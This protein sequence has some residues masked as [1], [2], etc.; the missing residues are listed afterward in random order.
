[1]TILQIS[2]YAP[3]DNDPTNLMQTADDMRVGLH[4]LTITEYT[5]STV[6]AIAAGSVI[7]VNGTLFKA[8]SETAISGSPSNGT[9]YVYMVPSGSSPS[10]VLTPTFTNTAPTWFD[11]KQGWYDATGTYRYIHFAMTK[12]G[13]SY[14]PKGEMLFKNN[15]T[16]IVYSDGNIVTT[17]TI[18]GDLIGGVTETGAAGSVIKIKIINIGDWNMD[19]SAS[20]SLT[21]GL[22]HDDIRGV[23]A[24]IRDD[25]GTALYPLDFD[26]GSGA[27][28]RILL[29]S[30]QIQA[31]RTSGALFDGAS[32]DATSFNRGWV[33]IW[34]VA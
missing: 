29:S 7:E 33:S 16:V 10:Q 34:Y 20:I 12:S 22:T 24:F 15:S 3:S 27:A 31:Y 28:G 19:A 17:G 5:T 14:T 26:N 21:H 2:S 8:G 11:S 9:V 18:T 6:P 32:F 1:M 25:T 23:Y 13:S 30:T 4:E